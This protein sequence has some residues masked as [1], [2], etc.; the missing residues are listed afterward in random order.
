M[1]MVLR[2][3]FLG[4]YYNEFYNVTDKSNAHRLYYRPIC[5]CGPSVNLY[6]DID[7]HNKLFNWYLDIAKW[8]QF[9]IYGMYHITEDEIQ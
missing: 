2:S 9:W 1:V 4:P 8:L 6:L 7:G 5:K 3:K